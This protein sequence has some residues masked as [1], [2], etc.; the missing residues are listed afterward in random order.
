MSS[1][2]VT[3]RLDAA[4]GPRCYA[5]L[6]GKA[7][8]LIGTPPGTAVMPARRSRR[9]PAPV[10]ISILEHQQRQQALADTAGMAG[11]NEAGCGG[12]SGAEEH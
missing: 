9:Y 10:K 1:F 8:T 4:P 11:C 2:F 12:P 5:L 7:L 6:L 3:Q